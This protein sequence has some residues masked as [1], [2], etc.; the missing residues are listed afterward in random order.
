[1]NIAVIIRNNIFRK[2]ARKN[3]EEKQEQS[4]SYSDSGPE[5]KG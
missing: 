1:M 5:Q 3:E 4:E 2:G